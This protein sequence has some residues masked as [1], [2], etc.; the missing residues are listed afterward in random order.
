MTMTNSR[1]FRAIG[2]VRLWLLAGL[3]MAM[4]LLGNPESRID[5][6]LTA[7]PFPDLLYRIDATSNGHTASVLN[8]GIGY[9]GALQAPIPVDVDGDLLPDVTVAVN[10]LDTQGIHNPP[11]PGDIIRPNIEINRFPLELGTT[12]LGRPSPP[13]RITVSFTIRDLEGEAENMVASFGYDTAGGGSIPPYFQA[14]VD[15]LDDFF[16]PVTATLSTKGTLVTQPT[17]PLWY[18]GP[19]TVI[20]GFEQGDFDADLGLRYEP[21]PDEAVVTY[22]HD[23]EGNHLDYAH[24]YDGE[25]DLVTTASIDDGGERTEVTARVDRLPRT[26]G[27]DMIDSEDGGGIRY[28]S[29]ADGRL[30]DV[31]VTYRGALAGDVYNAQLAIEELPAF[32]EARWDMPDGGPAS[33]TFDSSGQG[34]GAI[35]ANITN[36]DGAVPNLPPLVGSENQLAA[37]Q[38]H[39][40]S[41]DTRIH[42]RVERIRHVSFRQT[43][44]GGLEGTFAAGD[45]EQ[46]LEVLGWLDLRADDLPL[47]NAAA[48][49]SPL[50][51]GPPEGSPTIALIPAGDDQRTDPLTLV[52]SA[53]EA[54][55]IDGHVLV[56]DHR[57]ADLSGAAAA[58]PSTCGSAGV[59]CG[60][61]RLRHIPRTITAR[62]GEFEGENGRREARVDVDT[63]GPGHADVFADVK[64]GPGIVGD[65][66]PLADTPLVAHVDLQGIPNHVRIRTIE[67]QEDTLERAEFHTCAYDYDADACPEGT[68]DERI[69]ALNFSIA[70]FLAQDRNDPDVGVP[71]AYAATPNFVTVTARGHDGGDTVRFEATGRIQDIRELTYVNDGAFGFRSDI[72]GNGALAAIV[73]AKNIALNDAE[74]RNRPN[75]YDVSGD[76][77]IDPL[78][79]KMSFCFNEAGQEIITPDPGAITA[80][81]LQANPF[82][83][84]PVP[85]QSPLSLSY[86]GRDGNGAPQEFNVT[87]SAELVDKGTTAAN[88]AD[89]RRVK[90]S[91]ELTHVPATIR[92][93]FLDPEHQGGPMR[94]LVEAPTLGDQLRVEATAAMLDADLQCQDP[95]V[96]AS[97]KQALCAHAV[98]DNVPERLTLD[99]DPAAASDNFVL[100][101]SGEKQLDLTE[102]EVSSVAC[103]D[104]TG[105]ARVLIAT[106]EILD[107]PQRVEGTLRTPAPDKPDDPILVDL[108]ATP[109]LGAIN[110]YVRNFIAPDPV[111]GLP[112]QRDGLFQPPDAQL[113]DHT[114]NFDWVRFGQQGDAFDGEVHI[115]QVKRVGFKNQVDATGKR[116]DTSVVNLDFGTDKIIRGYVDLDKDGTDRLI[117][118]VTLSDIPAGTQVCFRGAKE[119]PALTP[120]PGT[121]TFCDGGNPDQGAFEV[122]MSPAAGPKRLDVDA[123]VRMAKG[124]G[125]D[126][127]AGRVRI[128][129]IP[130]VIRGA[131]GDGKIDIAGYDL[132]GTPDGIDRIRVHGASF[133]IT[134]DGWTDATRPYAQRLV[135]RQPFPAPETAN[136]HVTLRA[137]DDDFEVRARIGAVEG[138]GQVGSD[139]HRIK[140]QDT[141]CAKPTPVDYGNGPVPADIGTR[142]DF[143][144]LPTDDGT[145]HTCILGQFEPVGPTEVDPLD[146]S[147]VADKG[148]QRLSVSRAQL[149]DIP[150]FFQVNIADADP[151]DAGSE[152]PERQLRPHCVGEGL[153]QPPNCVAP[154]FRLDTPGNS[155]LRGLVEYGTV[156]D[157]TA[158]AGIKPREPLPD[159]VEPV[160]AAGNSLWGDNGMRARVGSFENSTAIRAGLRLLIPASVT[161]DQVGTWSDADLSNKTNYRDAS[162]LHIRFVARNR[163]GG[164]YASLGNMSGLVHNFG[165]GSQL[166]LSSADPDVGV[167][168]PGEVGLEVYNRN[169]NGNGRNFIQIDGR[170]STPLSI[171]AR[172]LGTGG[173]PVGR[174]DAQIRDIPPL[175][176]SEIATYSTSTA[177]SFRVRAEILGEGKEP[178]DPSGADAGSGGAPPK[179]DECTPLLCVA[180][181]VRLESAN[182]QFDFR[183]TPT[184]DYA[185]LLEAVVRTDG[186][187]NGVQVRA[188]EHIDGTGTAEFLAGAQIAVDPLNMFIHAGI[189]LL[190]SFD[191]VLMSDIDAA[192]SLGGTF[193]GPVWSAGAF[194]PVESTVPE[195]TGLGASD[196]A[197]RQNLLH[198]KLDHEGPAG[199]R[200]RI[201]P[202]DLNVDVMH[203]EAWALFV[204]LIGV[205][206]VP[207][208]SSLALPFLDCDAGGLL[209]ESGH[210]DATPGDQGDVV[211]WPFQPVGLPFGRIAYSGVLGGVATIAGALA[212]PFFCI[213]DTDQVLIDDGPTSPHPSVPLDLVF[214]GSEVPG[215]RVDA[216]TEVPTVT[217]PTP[218]LADFTV[219][220][221]TPELCGTFAF[222]NIHVP[223]GRTLRVA[224]T[225]NG[226]DING[227]SDVA[228]DNIP[229]ACPAGATVGQLH[230][231]GAQNVTV[232]GVIDASAVVTET[233]PSG[234][235][236]PASGNS[237]GG[238]G[239]FFFTGDGGNGGT[240][241]GGTGGTSYGDFASNLDTEVGAAGV[242]KAVAGAGNAGKGG[243]VVKIYADV[244]TVNNGGH[245]R[246]NG[247]SGGDVGTT[248]VDCAYVDPDPGDADGDTSKP[249]TGV[250][251]GGGGA[252]GGIVLNVAEYRLFGS[253][254]IEANGGRGGRGT[255]GAGGGGGGGVVKVSAALRNG[256]DPEAVGG[257]PGTNDCPADFGNA[258]GGEP[259]FAVVRQSPKSRVDI[260]DL[261]DFGFWHSTQG[262][263]SLVLPYSAAS[264]S[265]PGDMNVILCST[266][267]PTTT[268]MPAGTSLSSVL[269]PAVPSGATVHSPCGSVP[270]NLDPPHLITPPTMVD[271]HFIVNDN[272][273]DPPG[274]A[275]T[276]P[277]LGQAYYGFYTAVWRSSEDG[278]DCFDWIGMIQSGNVLAGVLERAEDEASCALLEEMPASPDIVVAVDNEDPDMFGFT[279]HTTAVRDA[280]GAPIA[281]AEPVAVNTRDITL[282]FDSDDNLSGVLGIDCS[283]SVTVVNVPPVEVVTP[284]V[285][286]RGCVTG[287]TVTLPD[288][289][290]THTVAVQLTDAAGNVDTF[291]ADVLL[292]RLA[293][294]ANA[295]PTSAADRDNGWYSASPHYLLSGFDDHGGTGAGTYRYQFD[296]A[297]ELACPDMPTCEIGAHP[298]DQLPGRGRHVLHWTGEDKVGNRLTGHDDPATAAVEGRPSLA[299]KIDGE[300]P[301]SE[302]LSVPAVPNGANNWYS[303]PTWI[304][305]GAFDQP[306]GSG[307]D[308]APDDASQI[309]A[310]HFTVAH[311]GPPVA[312][313]FDPTAPVAIRLEPGTS[314]V[315]WFASDQAGNDEPLVRCRTFMVDEADPVADLV[316]APTGPNGS[317]W[318]TTRPFLDPVV[319]DPQASGSGVGADS[320]ASSLCTQRPTIAVGAP[321]G[322]CISI[323]GSPF[324]TT[325][326]IDSV[327]ALRN[328]WQLGEGLHEVRVFATDRAGRRSAIHTEQYQV[329]ISTPVAVGRTLPARPATGKW[330]K[331]TPLVVLRADDGD[332]HGSGVAAIRYR[333]DGGPVQT[334]NG[335]FV[336]PQGLH[337]VSYWSEDR[338]GHSQV[339][340]TLRVAVDTTV[341]VPAATTPNPA[342][343]LRSKLGLPL[344]SPTVDLRWTL[345][346]N[347][348]GASHPDNAPPDK[349]Q[350]HVVVYDANGFPVRT[351]D[352]GKHVV[353]PGQTL[354]GTTKW[355]GKGTN[356]ALLPV[357]TYYYRV[358]ATD[359]AGNTA[360]SG[361]SA[362]LVIAVK[363]LL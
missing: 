2:S 304:T 252:G 152:A 331:R 131:V 14:T 342:L 87:A 290:G 165:D 71:S 273:V 264:Q 77:L 301:I 293:P 212:G 292:D 246:A 233:D 170:V 228:S 318:F 280:S 19:L 108:T 70:N 117:G 218:T 322:T 83:G 204:K 94:L 115:S 219:G 347:L 30:P 172:F 339:P 151:L 272:R 86:E 356:L 256:G 238:H 200:S 64:V 99:Y 75:I 234:P 275:F 359:A 297:T 254:S 66:T 291:H 251:G 175:A 134:D 189:P 58:D 128:D 201:G 195:L 21:F 129:N 330:F 39:A 323:D 355:D 34:I 311:N 350:V 220:P 84:P 253:G 72:G 62:I 224:A 155:T 51:S 53:L 18:R 240:P 43:E 4:G 16:N 278:N 98:V 209:V 300:P 57:A 236:S 149:D 174:V 271:R 361:E 50:P 45:G 104:D 24:A 112:A 143:P 319:T 194:D 281:G 153:S 205:D 230:L 89:D 124:G 11:Q 324:V 341:P 320:D 229:G 286:Y 82:A 47:I 40:A 95:R 125:T 23:D 309:A 313:T 126:V 173:S 79:Q 192:F 180:T 279:V 85:A 214:T 260:S 176:A 60:D 210:F 315:C 274:A 78:P 269:L 81:C 144:H 193:D 121:A 316:T 49:L 222:N 1:L 159:P 332:R 191:F 248:P 26:I 97:G 183:P 303:G 179:E 298:T 188:R 187:K 10:L 147:L 9:P 27:L 302:L 345:K 44:A 73:D 333:L 336:V 184:S 321:T 261:E 231:I 110:A 48:T 20:G 116:L 346:E 127:L 102:L 133:D 288:T 227:N 223:G 258:T 93:H 277:D 299:V 90:G 37:L 74:G 338:A 106:G 136:Q 135:A 118:D 295:A 283:P 344:T 150:E 114:D 8:L 158:L 354:N 42:A 186:A 132:D 96:P 351:L 32:M 352:A 282:T 41:G 190:A 55:D 31:D 80:P 257:S 262:D 357:G 15:G 268:E 358:V 310:V 285:G 329:D 185:R 157:V 284:V 270:M 141:P 140:V 247:G 113:L 138:S 107:L 232:D 28:D 326:H 267:K 235:G 169:H 156:A 255:A 100:D 353:T 363:L 245:I 166:L 243:G 160:D 88:V 312:A 29:T 196:V 317:G 327:L 52:Y 249:N 276:L 33:A 6:Q 334:Y 13:L 340:Q 225:T 65:G 36:H 17:S 25:V 12:L 182:V 111:P 221:S 314:E 237:G 92:A 308:K 217:Q 202:I 76:V 7:V 142:D 203:G 164:T 177:P 337:V 287:Q 239:I 206:W 207:P 266:S 296:E 208:G 59:V 265:G 168:I 348:S 123:F 198:I 154:L 119:H 38:H 56:R 197:L 343:W 120:A 335:P 307:F 349:V 167:A 328:L 289:D 68:E 5:P 46:A 3:F 241:G 360:M 91:V 294:T 137:D 181:Q 105:R 216:I 35:E 130:N 148:G 325:E 22:S 109:P 211:A 63:V 305:F 103:D 306:G 61:L 146:L 145:N 178:P 250:P 163:D 101:S 161:V 362:K 122:R 199:S 67:G 139:L 69:G 259:G 226:L 213:V 244:L 263:K 242:T 171:R 54:V 162:D 215:A